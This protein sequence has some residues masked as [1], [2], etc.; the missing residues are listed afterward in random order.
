MKRMLLLLGVIAACQAQAQSLP[1]A[2]FLP[3]LVLPRETVDMATFP[4]S[5]PTASP[6]API[7]A[8]RYT[9]E[10]VSKSL[11][12]YQSEAKVR[13]MLVLKDG[14]IVYEYNNFP[15]TK[16]SLHQS[17]SMAKQVLSAM[18]GIAIGEGAIRSVN[19]RMDAYEPALAVNG[20]AGVTF[21]Q[22]LQM[23]SGVAYSEE[24]DRFKLFMDT[25]ADYYTLG[26]SGY[27][28]REKTTDTVLAPAFAPGSKYQYASINSQ[29]ISMALEKAVGMPYQRYLELKLW[30]PMR[31]PDRAKVLVDRSH[32]AFTFCCL[33]ATTRSYA[34]FGLLYA[35]E[36][37]LH[38]RQIVSSDWVRQS[39]T[40]A[41]DPTNWHAVPVNGNKLGLYGFGYHWW[42][43]EGER[44]DF[45]AL[46]VFGQAIHVLPKQNTVIV[47]ISGDFDTP[48]AHI[49]ENVVMGRA[50]A[51]Y[52]D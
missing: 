46:G 30:K 32:E 11:S 26:S 23:S 24:A 31:T 19:D 33:Y 20:F 10:G 51:D 28:L 7:S 45:S 48:G 6:K 39:T 5:M 43:L 25:I 40:F 29:A 50:L 17:W 36:G 14:K 27:T 35:Q 9:Y 49:E 42:P 47:R 1:P 4:V 16:T 3:E 44:Q 15:Y 18:V 8:L 41:G 38:G 12:Q 2:L 34:M 22:A 52:L 13:A 37:R 21:K